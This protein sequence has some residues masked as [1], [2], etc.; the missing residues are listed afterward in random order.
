MKIDGIDVRRMSTGSVYSNSSSYIEL[1]VAEGRLASLSNIF[2]LYYYYIMRVV[3]FSVVD[4]R[5]V[6][7]DPIRSS[8]NEAFTLVILSGIGL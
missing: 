4:Y 3:K 7:I 1:V 6:A 5:I 8:A 2:L